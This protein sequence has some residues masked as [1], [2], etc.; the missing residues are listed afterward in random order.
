M[1]ADFIEA[2]TNGNEPVIS[3]SECR[4]DLGIVLACYD[5]LRNAAPVAL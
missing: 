5:S 2:L 4:R 3:V 1:L